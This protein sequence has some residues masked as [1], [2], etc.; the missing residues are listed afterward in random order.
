MLQDD[1][2]PGFGALLPLGVLLCLVWGL[3]NPALARPPPADE[4]RPSSHVWAAESGA[5]PAAALARVG[6]TLPRDL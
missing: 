4:Q 3:T 6:F 2:R 5:E 1:Q